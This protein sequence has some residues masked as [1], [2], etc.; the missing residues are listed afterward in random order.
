V[1]KGFLL[2]VFTLIV[3]TIVNLSAFGLTVL[4]V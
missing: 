1:L 3:D 2:L 4:L